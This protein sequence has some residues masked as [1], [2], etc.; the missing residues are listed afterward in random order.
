MIKYPPSH[1]IFRKL[2]TQ[3]RLLKTY[4]KRWWNLWGKE[5]TES[6][7]SMFILTV[8]YSICHQ[9]SQALSQLTHTC[10]LNKRK[11][12]HHTLKFPS[13]LCDR[14]RLAKP[15]PLDDTSH[16]HHQQ[17]RG[18]ERKLC[19]IPNCQEFTN[20]CFNLTAN[21]TE[22]NLLTGKKK[23]HFI[24]YWRYSYPTGLWSASS[25]S[26]CEEAGKSSQITWTPSGRKQSLSVVLKKQTN[27]EKNTQSINFF[28]LYYIH[29]KLHKKPN[30]LMQVKIKSKVHNKSAL[31][32]KAEM[33]KKE[34]TQGYK[35]KLCFFKSVL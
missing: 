11:I 29:S 24:P 5:V 10:K 18:C 28:Y 32:I 12:I 30:T 8:W 9:S 26:R 25:V 34:A 1:Q 16:P 6:M 19:L 4:K 27:K 3:V 17:L 22:R 33:K 21:N 20:K 14:P 2:N 7:H 35:R 15:A 13:L 31:I 23:I